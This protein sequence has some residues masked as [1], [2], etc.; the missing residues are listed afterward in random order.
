MLFTLGSA[1]ALYEGIHKLEDPEE[2]DSPVVADVILS[3]AI[4]LET[5]SLRTPSSSR[6]R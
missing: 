5:F 4:E 6:G 1:F 2:I 3:V